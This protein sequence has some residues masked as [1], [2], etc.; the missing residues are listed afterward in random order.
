MR[1]GGAMKRLASSVGFAVLGL[2]ST[3]PAN[4]IVEAVDWSGLT[5]RWPAGRCWE[6]DHCDVPWYGMAMFVSLFLVPTAVGALL[7]WRMAGT[8]ARGVA[9]NALLLFASTLV[10]FVVVRFASGVPSA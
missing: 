3:V 2:L 8:S 4:R 5:Y 10:V 7:G 1:W 9:L 6:I